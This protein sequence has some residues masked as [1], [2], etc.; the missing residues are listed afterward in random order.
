MIGKPIHT[1]VENPSADDEADRLRDA[2]ARAHGEATVDHDTVRTW[3]R[4]LADGKR[5]RP[6]QPTE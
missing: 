1:S 6:P 3:L 2:L 4:A 5:P